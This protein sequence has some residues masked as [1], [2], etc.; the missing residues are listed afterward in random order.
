M[1]NILSSHRRNTPAA[2]PKLC[3]KAPEYFTLNERVRPMLTHSYH[4]AG[5]IHIYIAIDPKL[6][7]RAPIQLGLHWY[8][9]VHRNKK[10]MKKAGYSFRTRHSM[11]AHEL[12]ECPKNRAEYAISLRLAKEWIAK[13]N[14][15]LAAQGVEV[16]NYSA[17]HDALY[18]LA[19]KE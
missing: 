13:H 8:K 14:A 12:V 6:Y 10:L 19:V 17:V 4:P 7:R 2:L 18:Q 5:Q 9:E 16:G 3:P 11:I 15:L 1:S